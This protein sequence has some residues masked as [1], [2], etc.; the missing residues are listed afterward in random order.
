MVTIAITGLKEHINVG[1]ILELEG[2]HYKVLK[3]FD[4]EIEGRQGQVMFCEIITVNK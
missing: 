2:I 3:E 4:C 1:R